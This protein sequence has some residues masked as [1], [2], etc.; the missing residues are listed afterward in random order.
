[1]TEY[2]V[3]KFIL[4]GFIPGV[5]ITWMYHRLKEFSYKYVAERFESAYYF[6]SDEHVKLTKEY[7]R[8][9][10]Q[11]E[12]ITKKTEDF[13][14]QAMVDYTALEAKYYELEEDT[15]EK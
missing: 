11:N 5:L 9:K 7:I 10:K 8:L 15:K 3:I 6:Q 4:I 14:E 12:D 13:V 2:E 1:M